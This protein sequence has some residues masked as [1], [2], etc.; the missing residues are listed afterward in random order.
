MQ[1]CK[2]YSEI[3]EFSTNPCLLPHSSNLYSCPL[4]SDLYKEPKLED[5]QRLFL[6]PTLGVS[7]VVA[8]NW[9]KIAFNRS[10][11]GNHHLPPN[12]SVFTL[13]LFLIEAVCQKG[14]LVTTELTVVF[15]SSK[16]LSDQVKRIKIL[17][18]DQ[19][20]NLR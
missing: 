7:P 14:N 11:F 2:K 3:A 20:E 18:L 12:P 10:A 16:F 1:L 4:C 17:A 6:F 5:T 13:S 19:A 15:D 8:L 9:Q